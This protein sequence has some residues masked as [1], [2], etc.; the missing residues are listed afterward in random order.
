MARRTPANVTLRWPFEVNK[1]A[2]SGPEDEQSRG[3][4]PLSNEAISP[5]QFKLVFFNL[6]DEY[7]YKSDDSSEAWIS[8][9]DVEQW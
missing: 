9:E 4:Q 1:A 5:P 6:K 2:T 7:H 3:K 8:K